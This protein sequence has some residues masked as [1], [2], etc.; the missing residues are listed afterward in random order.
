MDL[1]AAHRQTG[2]RGGQRIPEFVLD[3]RG[4]RWHYRQALT[5][6]SNG[7]E[8]RCGTQMAQG[9]RSPETDFLDWIILLLCLSHER[10]RS[11]AVRKAAPESMLRFLPRNHP[12]E[13]MK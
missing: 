6:R 7:E 8:R 5:S 13:A 9:M 12:H 11:F 2:G 3:G 4:S 10:F 1:H